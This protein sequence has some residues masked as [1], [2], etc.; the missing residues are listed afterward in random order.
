MPEAC[1]TFSIIATL[2]NSL[3]GHFSPLPNRRS[4][5]HHHRDTDTQRH[6]ETEYPGKSLSEEGLC[7][8]RRSLCASV[9]LW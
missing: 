7:R 6:R 5:S 3:N 8:L 2:V 1:G 4:Q 9:S